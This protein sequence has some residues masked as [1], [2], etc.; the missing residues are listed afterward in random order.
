MEAEHSF[1]NNHLVFSLKE[2]TGQEVSGP[3][4][5]ARALKQARFAKGWTQVE[6]AEQLSVPKRSIVSWETAERVPSI[7]MVVILLDGLC[8]S[9][10]WSL[11]HELLCAYIVDDLERQERREDRKVHQNTAFLQRIQRLMER[12]LELPAHASMEVASKEQKRVEE[13]VPDQGDEPLPSQLTG[14]QHVLEPLF[15]LMNQLRRHPELIPVARDFIR[16]M[17]PSG[18]MEGG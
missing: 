13:A 1:F 3:S 5:F 14:E 16:E 8:S 17:A 15:A 4:R 9:S 2:T 11:Q 6:L 18:E 10:E 12:V 7:G